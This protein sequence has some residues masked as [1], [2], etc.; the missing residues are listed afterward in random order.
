MAEKG[1]LLV[2]PRLV[3]RPF[4]E[5]DAEALFAVYSDSEVTKYL[6][7]EPY[8]KVA[9][10]EA[11]IGGLLKGEESSVFCRAIEMQETGELVGSIKIEINEHDN[12]GEAVFAVG[13]KYW[14]QGIA[15][16]AVREAVVYLMT[17]CGLNRIS[18]AHAVTNPAAGGVLRKVGMSYE[19]VARQLF[20][21]SQGYHDCH[22][23][24]ILKSD[25]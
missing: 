18:G 20:R 14:G 6:R 16:E 11:F 3:L 10:A 2:T 15:S 8:E 21:N 7:R 22:R 19:G 12:C 13:R 9:D 17:Q 1:N 25:I 23:Y 4:E 24:A 5:K